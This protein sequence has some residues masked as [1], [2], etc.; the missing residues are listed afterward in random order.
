MKIKPILTEICQDFM[1]SIREGLYSTEDIAKEYFSKIFESN[2]ETIYTFKPKTPLP[3]YQVIESFIISPSSPSSNSV[4]FFQ[5][6]WSF[7]TLRLTKFNNSILENTNSD[8]YYPFSPFNIYR[9]TQIEKNK[10]YS[11]LNE[12]NEANIRETCS[13]QLCD[14]QKY[15]SIINLN[16]HKLNLVIQQNASNINKYVVWVFGEIEDIDNLEDTENGRLKDIYDVGN[17]KLLNDIIEALKINKIYDP[18][19]HFIGVNNYITYQMKVLHL[20]LTPKTIYASQSSAKETQSD[21]IMESRLSNILN[22]QYALQVYGSYLT[23]YK[24]SD[25]FVI[26]GPYKIDTIPNLL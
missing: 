16:Q 15:E 14:I 25:Y 24:N 5:N 13:N 8:N 11:A 23:E 7:P 4:N 9:A 21:F 20:K 10:T 3:I 12:A 26:F 22:I 18:K 2:T 17:A 19:I 6:S 1:K